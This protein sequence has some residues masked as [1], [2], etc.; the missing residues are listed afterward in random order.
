MLVATAHIGKLVSIY[1]GCEI[2]F[3]S[4]WKPVL[5]AVHL[6]SFPTPPISSTLLW[7]QE[8]FPPL[9]VESVSFPLKAPPP[10]YSGNKLLF[11]SRRGPHS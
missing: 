10:S 11:Y 9:W 6:F 5:L 4:K 7:T 1:E 2:N 8:T 3:S